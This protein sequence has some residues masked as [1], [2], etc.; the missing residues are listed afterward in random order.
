MPIRRYKA[1]QTG[2]KSHEGG[3][4]DGFIKLSNQVLLDAF[5]I[6]P[7]IIPAASQTNMAINNFPQATG[8]SEVLYVWRNEIFSLIEITFWLLYKTY[9]REAARTLFLL[10]IVCHY[11]PSLRDL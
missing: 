2:A 9:A 10:I 8:R 7:L 5:P 1:V 3:F 4:Q 6:N 11:T